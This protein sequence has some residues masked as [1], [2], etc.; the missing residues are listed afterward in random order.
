MPDTWLAR[1]HPRHGGR[2]VPKVEIDGSASRR[3]AEGVE[4]ESHRVQKALGASGDPGMIERTRRYLDGHADPV[5]AAAVALLMVTNP[6][7]RR[8]FVPSWV[9]D[10]WAADHGVAFAACATAELDEV[11]VVKTGGGETPIIHYRDGG[12]RLRGKDCLLRAR[13]LLA[14]AGAGEYREAVEGLARHRRSPGQ[15]LETAYLAPTRLDWVEHCCTDPV[16]TG[17]DA[18][19]HHWMLI[20]AVSTPVHAD[21]LERN[22][23]PNRY[24]LADDNIATMVDALGEAAVP[25]LTKWMHGC[26]V[27]TVKILLRGLA[28]VPSD[29]A[30]QVL[31]DRVGDKHAQPALIEAMRRFPVRALRLLGPVAA[32]ASRPAEVAAD[33]LRGHLRAHRDL[34][35]SALPGLPDEARKVIEPMLDAMATDLVP[36]APADAL[37]KLLVEPPWTARRKKAKPVV[38]TGLTAPS[39]TSIVWAPG[40]RDR[41][42]NLYNTPRFDADDPDEVIARFRRMGSYEVVN[43]LAGGPED[44]ARWLLERWKPDPRYLHPD[45]YAT[46]AV[47]A[48]FEYDALHLVSEVLNAH[49]SE[50]GDLLLPYLS[51]ETAA[52][53]ARWLARVRR[54]R[55]VALAWFDRHGLEAVPFLVPAAL[56]KP[57][58]ARGDAEAALRLLASRHGAAP[59]VEAARAHGDQAADAIAAMLDTDPLDALPPRMPKLGA[60]AD[61]GL[62]PQ[63]L[64]RGRDR[65]LPAEAA[66]HLLTMLAISKPD[67]VYPGVYAVRDLCDPESLAGF[68]WEV[69]RRWDTHG[70][71]SSDGWALTQLGMLGD[72]GTVRR[73]SPLLRAWA[74]EKRTP[75]MAAGLDVL[76]AIGSDVALVHLNGIA[77]SARSA[78]LKK[79]ARERLG[80]VAADLELTPEQLDDRLAPAFGLD[81]DGGMTLD[82]GPRRFRVGF[83]EQLKPYVIDPDGKPRK[84][85]PKPSASDDPE[86]GPAAHKR[87]AALKKDVATVAADQIRRL[88]RALADQRRWP[89]AEF[90][91]FVVEHPLVWHLA[92]R[93]VWTG[94]A[95]GRTF[96]FR[97]AEDRTFADVTDDAVTLPAEAE[98]VIAHPVHLGEELAAWSDVFADYEIIQPFPQLGRRVHALTD[99]EGAG[100]RLA[101]FEGLEVPGGKLLGLRNRAW[102]ASE[103]EYGSIDEI[104]RKIAPG[105]RAVIAFRPGFQGELYSPDLEQKITRVSVVAA[106]SPRPRPRLADLDPAVTSEIIAD[107]TNLTF[108]PPT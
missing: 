8:G 21:L 46:R 2:H 92:R 77:L 71:Q 47:L 65:A 48:R 70:A 91:A 99:E 78:A 58:A 59:I 19:M 66:G 17:R 60:W 89:A 35:V 68:A 105:H 69:F 23:S 73:L 76:A 38:I 34:A 83:D 20:C 36:D 95:E 81:D 106:D 31:V 55:K 50:C 63:V 97:I 33:M 27:D 100:D 14:A 75:R 79:Q 32:G 16:I 42:A 25:L 26:E 72:D 90:R 5:G 24:V 43:R 29:E 53:A 64:L 107:L 56:A 57:G 12:L 84:A 94:E 11:E 6:L 87:F 85:L 80:Q 4:K 1:A 54:Q 30:V 82:Y 13:A 40:E 44:V 67:E 15:R 62:L 18:R 3:L 61:P 10:A 22:F 28:A 39:T 45:Y 41:W 93:L 86:L 9:V 108:Q 37:P 49:K 96:T 98:V 51:A 101:R 52:L 102:D 103:A 104:S 74:T 7:G 88:E